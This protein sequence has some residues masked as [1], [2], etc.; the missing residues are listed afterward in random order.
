MPRAI[1]ELNAANL[2][3]VGDSLAFGHLCLQ[4]ISAIYFSAGHLLR[5]SGRGFWQAE[6]ALHPGR[7]H[8]CPPDDPGICSGAGWLS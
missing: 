5:G 8:S 6:E 2:A 3:V 4:Y 1:R 7:V